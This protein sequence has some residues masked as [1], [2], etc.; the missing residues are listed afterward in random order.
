VLNSSGKDD[1]FK[2]TKSLVSW[3][4]NTFNWN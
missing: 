1:R 2:E 4:F 3:I